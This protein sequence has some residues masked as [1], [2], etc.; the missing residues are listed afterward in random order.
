M[1]Q[2]LRRPSAIIDTGRLAAAGGS[3]KSIVKTINHPHRRHCHEGA[4]AV[5]PFPFLILHGLLMMKIIII[6]VTCY[7]NSRVMT[8]INFLANGTSVD[9]NFD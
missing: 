3:N 1:G 9:N 7:K 8:M 4:Y 5:F 6:I 2:G